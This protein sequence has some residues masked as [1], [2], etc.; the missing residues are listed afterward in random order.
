MTVAGDKIE[1][2]VLKR[3]FW[4]KMYFV[5]CILLGVTFIVDGCR[6]GI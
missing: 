3:S 4:T 6:G 2:F 1:L 5:C